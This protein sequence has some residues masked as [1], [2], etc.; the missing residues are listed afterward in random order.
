[1]RGS[2]TAMRR[3]LGMG[4]LVT[5][6]VSALLFAG[7]EA[8]GLATITTIAGNGVA[9]FGGDGGAA[10]SGSL[11]TPAGVAVAAPAK[12]IIGDID[13][14]RVRM[15]N[16]GVITTIAGTGTC[17]FGGDG[18]PATAAD[19]RWPKGVAVYS[20]GDVYIAD[21]FNC[22]I[23][24]I[25]GGVITTVAGNGTCSYGGDAGSAT[26]ASLNVPEGV[27]V[28]G[29]G[30]LY[31]ADTGNCRIRRVSGG[32]IT[33]IAGD[34]MCIDGGDGG[35]ATGAHLH[36]PAS[37]IVDSHGI[38]Y[39]ADTYN[40]RVRTITAGTINTI[41]GDG[42]CGYGGDG[43]ASTSASLAYPYS[44]ALDAVGNLYVADTFNCRVREISAGMI[45]TIA[46]NGT[47]TF[48]GDGG[49]G[50]N[51]GLN[52]PLGLIVDNT[53]NLF[54]ADSG[55]NRI[56]EVSPAS[57]GGIAEQP[58]VTASPSS[59]ASSGRDHKVYFPGVVAVLMVAV[60][61]TAGWRKRRRRSRPTSA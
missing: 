56:R 31:I 50:T 61:G 39:V 57:V 17:A 6:L 22:R 4:S 49:P 51:A 33:T 13:N 3:W 38:V 25:S 16:G 35:P 11:H 40:C 53:G 21:S 19:L 2:D 14:C 42:T 32:T 58:D 30:N 9:G 59:S 15:V 55:N 29:T 36:A 24:K 12:L 23:R 28:D 41:A 48:D 43:G 47:C 7:S 26:S 34:G 60:A 27:A 5:A 46:G 20:N 1:V 8:A 54:V 44:L 18:G 10:T 52:L 45:N 37:V